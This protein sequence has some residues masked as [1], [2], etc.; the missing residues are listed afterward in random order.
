[1]KTVI[2]V[3]LA[4]CLA[5]VGV[6]K[7]VGWVPDGALVSGYF[8]NI[9]GVIEIVAGLVL[10]LLPIARRHVCSGVVAL[11]IVGAAIS[12]VRPDKPCGCMGSLTGKH[13][14]LALSGLGVLATSGLLLSRDAA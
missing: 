3:M 10:L 1:M 12:L 7:V 2:M 5:C 14:L 11:C 9:I 13:Y 8:A 6:I 4:A